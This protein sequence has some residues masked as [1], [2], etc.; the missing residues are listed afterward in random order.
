MKYKLIAFDVTN[1]LEKSVGELVFA[2]NPK[3]LG[4]REEIEQTGVPISRRALEG[5]VDLSE[6][7]PY[8]GE[9]ELAVAAKEFAKR[10][11]S[12]PLIQ[13][14][15]LIITVNNNINS[16][17]QL[18]KL[19]DWDDKFKKLISK[20]II[21]DAKGITPQGFKGITSLT[22]LTELSINC[23]KIETSCLSPLADMPSLKTLSFNAIRFD[24][25][26]FDILF[27]LKDQLEL[28][29]LTNTNLSADSIERIRRFMKKAS[30]RWT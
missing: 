25:S 8:F 4:V 5:L 21:C 19:W 11:N 13:D 27:K 9:S 15:G 14:G 6:V 2:I 10:F 16:D 20:F 24:D 22:N 30:M 17:A 29:Q 7:L 3:M 12:S 28:L 1:A 26:L 23:G 18:A